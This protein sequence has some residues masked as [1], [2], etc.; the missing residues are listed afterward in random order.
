E[1]AA[2]EVE[3]Q[4]LADSARALASNLEE[5]V[6]NATEVDEESYEESRRQGEG[7]VQAAGDAYEAVLEVGEG[8]TA[9]Q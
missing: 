3:E 4:G 1:R 8:D 7:R 9:P 5:R 2:E 6:E